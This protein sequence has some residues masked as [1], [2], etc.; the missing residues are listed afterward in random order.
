M[1]T[2]VDSSVLLA[3]FNGEPSAASWMDLLI[4]LRRE[5]QLVICDVVY[6][7]IAPAFTTEADLQEALRKLGVSFESI[8]PAAAWRAGACFRAYRDAGGPRR[9]LIPD[10]L[11]AAHAQVQADCLAAQ[12]RGYLRCYFP[13]LRLH[14]RPSGDTSR[15]P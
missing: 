6:A 15:R 3:V 13:D 11:I 4:L 14:G 9:H 7:E 10:F 1:R 2:A 8:S 5:G 12:D